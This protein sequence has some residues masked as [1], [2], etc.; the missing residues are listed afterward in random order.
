MEDGLL[1]LK[2]NNHKSTFFHILG[3]LRGKQTY[4]DATLACEGKFF[5]VH[6]LVMST[7]S[8]YFGEIFEKTPCKNPVVVLKDIQKADLDALLDY[9]YIGE[10]DVRQSDLAGLIKAAEC[11]RIKGLAV[12]DEDPSKVQKKG[13]S[14]VPER[15]EESPPAKRKKRDSGDVGRGR[16]PPSRP[17][18]SSIPPAVPSQASSSSHSQRTSTQA[19]PV[20]D[21]SPRT[22]SQVP[23]QP[24]ANVHGSDT[25]HVDSHRSLSSG[26]TS[27]RQD[28]NQHLPSRQQHDQRSTTP[29][30]DQGT[31]S[32]SQPESPSKSTDSHI[33][34]VPMIKVEVEDGHEDNT[35]G[36]DRHRDGDSR[37]ED[38]LDDTSNDFPDYLA[39]G[40]IEKE[41][42]DQ[43]DS[44][45]A[46]QI[47]GPSGLQGAHHILGWGE[48][49]D[50]GFPHNLFGEDPAAQ[51]QAQRHPVAL[52]GGGGGS[53]R[54]EV[55]VEGKE[56]VED[57]V[58]ERGPVTASTV[59]A[60]GAL[61]H[62]L[63]GSPHLHLRPPLL[64]PHLHRA[65]HA[66]PTQQPQLQQH[67]HL[68]SADDSRGGNGGG[69]GG[70]GGE[71]GGGTGVYGTGDSAWYATTLGNH[72]CPVCGY[73]SSKLSNVKAHLLTHTGE[74][75]YACPLCSYRASKKGNLKRHMFH[76]H[77]RE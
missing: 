24:L 69:G 4:T 19:S 59:L 58:V 21:Q 72:L 52:E 54:E 43:A 53:A 26:V 56:V 74:K 11:L 20:P 25:R 75:P 44:Y 71:S 42:H 14:N 31:T 12:P 73:C 28:A 37:G 7:C 36:S 46:E 27:P 77:K 1:S 51:Q 10:V 63:A 2:W 35:T 17:Q 32:G 13:L 48:E 61:A 67:P 16:S 62:P 34:P 22:P 50:T 5:P 6:K 18:P 41:E 15:R 45:G 39:Q 29:G 49:G 57:G 65:P 68:V 40:E 8:D 47:P 60:G 55:C 3:E 23:S 9:M 30:N 70:G 64:P 76:I 38:H 33:F 66:P